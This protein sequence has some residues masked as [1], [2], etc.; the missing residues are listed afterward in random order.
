MRREGKG[1]E[2]VEGRCVREIKEASVPSNKIIQ[3]PKK[4][5]KKKKHF[6][7]PCLGESLLLIILGFALCTFLDV[8][9]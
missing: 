6:R 4:K 1:G 9:I 7:F 5:K 2:G 3:I 8:F